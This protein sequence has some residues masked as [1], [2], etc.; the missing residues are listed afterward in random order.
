MNRMHTLSAMALAMAFAAPGAMAQNAGS[1][2]AAGASAQAGQNAP[3]G[4]RTFAMQAAAGGMAEVALGNMAKEKGKSDA[5]RQY[6]EHM[7]A[8]HTKANEELKQIA[9]AKG[10][11]LPAEPTSQQKADAAR[12]QKLE[13]DAFDRAYAAQMVA[14]HVKTVSLFEKE[15]KSGR[16]AELKAFAAKTLPN[17]REH[18]K[19][20]RAL[21]NQTKV[22]M[23][24]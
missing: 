5:V 22:A 9:G 14:D 6:G 1:T 23:P 11:A 15:A 2:T 19:M 10:I 20:A 16:D 24:K 21:P 17:L 8:D 4:D 7:V 18:L 13:G 3:K 12:L